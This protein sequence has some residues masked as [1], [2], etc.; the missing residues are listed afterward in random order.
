MSQ[1]QQP[2]TRLGPV[3]GCMCY[4]ANTPELD[5]WCPCR[6][7]DLRPAA[8]SATPPDDGSN[9]ERLSMVTS[10]QGTPPER[11]HAD[12]YQDGYK[13]F[14]ID[15]ERDSDDPRPIRIADTHQNPETADVLMLAPETAR[16]IVSKIRTLGHDDAVGVRNAGL[17]TLG[18]TSVPYRG[19][20]VLILDG[21]NARL[22]VPQELRSTFVDRLEMA[23]ALYPEMAG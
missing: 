17:E 12:L 7:V 22:V 21:P 19:D 6:D 4:G 1:Q 8:E 14:A 9:Q 15:A 2:Q 16:E 18:V 3:K 23:A 13:L 20:S 5:G 10:P 11:F